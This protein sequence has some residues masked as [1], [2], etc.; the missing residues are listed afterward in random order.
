MSIT[1]ENPEITPDVEA[2]D[3]PIDATAVVEHASA[4]QPVASDLSAAPQ[5][6]ARGIVPVVAVSEAPEPFDHDHQSGGGS[7]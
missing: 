6:K 4:E 7:F 3:V 5:D 1:P 2:A